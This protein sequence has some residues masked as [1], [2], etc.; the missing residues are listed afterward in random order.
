MALIRAT[1]GSGGSQAID[2]NYVKSVVDSNTHTYDFSAQDSRAT[3]NSG[4]VYIDT[5]KKIAYLYAD[6]T[7]AKNLTVSSGW[8]GVLYLPNG[9]YNTYMP[10]N[11]YTSAG[12]FNKVL[13]LESTTATNNPS[14][15]LVPYSDSKAY[16]A[17]TKTISIGE[18]FKVYALWT[19][20]D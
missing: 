15:K 2:Y 19:L 6:F 17:A 11:A 9:F 4:G 20:Q 1:S 12:N 5:T 18:N 7:I 10:S 14:M 8:S 13:S 16:I 3:L